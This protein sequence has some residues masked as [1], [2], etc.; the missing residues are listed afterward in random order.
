MAGPQTATAEIDFTQPPPAAI[1]FSQPPPAIE[2]PSATERLGTN[3]L[4]GL[5]VTSDEQAKHFFAHPLDTVL[6]SFE[7]Q[8]EL[9]K[10]A[11]EA[12]NRGDY[13]E[14]LQHGLNY[15]VPFVGQQTDQAGTQLKEGDIAGGVGRTLGAAVPIIA[16]SPEVQATAGD[17]AAA[18]V[19]KA[20]P[21]LK[22]VKQAARETASP[23]NIGTAVGGA[24]GAKLGAVVGEPWGGGAA[25][26][27]F[28]RAA[29]QRIG[30][31]WSA[32][33]TLPEE[34]QAKGTRFSDPGAPLPEHP[35]AELLQ[36]RSLEQGGHAPG[37]TPAAALATIPNRASRV[38]PNLHA[39]FQPRAADIP[40]PVGSAGNPFQD[41][42]Q[43]PLSSLSGET[44][45]PVASP[46]ESLPTPASVENTPKTLNGESVLNQ[47]LGGRDNA[48]L[49]KVARSRGINVT[50]EAQLKA[51]VANKAIIGKIIDDFSP[52]ELQEIRDQAIENNRF[53]HAFGDIGEEAWNTMALQTY[54]PDIKIPASQLI[55]TKTAITNAP[56]KNVTPETG[57][58]GDLAAQIKKT[59]KATK[60]KPAATAPATDL[61]DQV[62]EMLKQVKAGKT[63]RDLSAQ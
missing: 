62:A 16:G 11:R 44:P 38:A 7:A 15:M 9:A 26:A 58:L 42:A 61:E 57:A 43:R 17:V 21:V 1:D 31:L 20:A 50:K 48:T 29:G 34:L 12:Y 63:L 22:V 49:L 56:L 5:G 30:K 27:A 39:A 25:G 4:S 36:A 8:G 54:F 59:A 53:R 28:G 52:E 10:K 33:K 45:A 18:A 55:R 32:Y 47:V 60:A 23:E 2:K 14:A 35:P 6:K 51:G 3:F 41:A 46:A 13:M 40:G 37:P 19:A 24:A